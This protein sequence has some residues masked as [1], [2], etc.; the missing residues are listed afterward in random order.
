MVLNSSISTHIINV[1][2]YPKEVKNC[3]ISRVTET[4]TPESFKKYVL[5]EFGV[6]LRGDSFKKW[7]AVPK[8]GRGWD[9]AE[10]ITFHPGTYTVE[11]RYTSD[12]KDL[13]RKNY[14]KHHYI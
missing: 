13:I 12:G 8:R 14:S 10:K 5:E 2:S 6:E 3:L 9:F 11:F 1:S 7:L 4:Y